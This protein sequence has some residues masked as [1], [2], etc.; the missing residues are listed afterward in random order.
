MIEID[1]HPKFKDGSVLRSWDPYVG[2]TGGEEE[3]AAYLR[4]HPELARKAGQS[5]VTVARNNPDLARQAAQ[6]AAE[7][8]QQ[9]V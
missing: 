5:A 8:R 9:P 1:R 3:M 7:Q 4:R 6:G 2:Y